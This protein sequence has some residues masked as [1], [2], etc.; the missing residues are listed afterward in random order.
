MPGTWSPLKPLRRWCAALSGC[1]KGA[2]AVE[3]A[4]VAPVFLVM[5]MGVVEMG[6]VLWIKAAMQHAV[7]QTT[8]Y[9]MVTNAACTSNLA[10]CQATL[11]TYATS[12]LGE[13]GLA[14]ADFN[15][16]AVETI[17]SSTTYMSV[18]ITYA[19]TP[20]V[21]IVEFPD[22]SLSAVARVPYNP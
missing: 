6:R 14:T 5:T 20:L 7:E 4:L 2:T 12:R 3:F 10:A 17:I 15:V 21:E 8:R 18:T 11:Q 9:F 22:V 13:S 19:F 1:R 16:T